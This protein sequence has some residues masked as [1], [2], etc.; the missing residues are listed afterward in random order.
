MVKK[1]HKLEI[2]GGVNAHYLSAS[3]SCG[4]FSKFMNMPHRGNSKNYREF[5]NKE[6]KTHKILLGAA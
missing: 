3:C 4:K 2:I 6:F 5:I 1:I